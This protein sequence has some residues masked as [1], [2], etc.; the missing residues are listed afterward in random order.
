MQ[1]NAATLR[2]E[3]TALDAS[4]I[5]LKAAKHQADGEVLDLKQQNEN[6]KRNVAWLEQQ[7]QDLQQTLFSAQEKA[8]KEVNPVSTKT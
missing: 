8:Q 4:N 6:L 5:E 2:K 7:N 1:S 3:N